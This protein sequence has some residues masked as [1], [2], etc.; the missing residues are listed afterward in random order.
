MLLAVFLQALLKLLESCAKRPDHG[1]AC[2]FTALAS[3]RANPAVLM[4]LGVLGTFGSA[5]AASSGT[6]L[7]HVRD[8]ALIGSR[9]PRHNGTRR[10]AD[11]RAIQV[12]SDALPQTV[13]VLFTQ[14]GVCTGRAGLR[15][16]V[17][18]FDAP[19]DRVTRLCPCL[20]MRADNL[21]SMHRKPPRC[22]IK[23]QCA[24]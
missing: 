15:A 13:E 10:V 11:V 7:K 8:C 23:P 22:G 18:F 2:V 16:I 6:G 20:R 1:F 24:T 12:E 19:D 21:L 17:A 5:I 4:M 9:P 14:T 3:F